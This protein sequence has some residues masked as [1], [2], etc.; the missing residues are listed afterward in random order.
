MTAFSPLRFSTYA[1]D[2]SKAIYDL[3]EEYRMSVQIDGLTDM[4][5]YAKSA[6]SQASEA[7]SRIQV[8]ASRVAGRVSQV[9]EMVAQL[10]KAEAELGA[11][12]GEMTNGGPPLVDLPTVD[13]VQ[14]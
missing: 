12:L 11:A 3:S 10:D 6:I 7:A 4:V 9:N 8:S 1:Q 5:K 13:F 14:K 2:L